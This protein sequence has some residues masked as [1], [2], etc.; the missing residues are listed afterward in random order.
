[1]ERRAEVAAYGTSGGWSVGEPQ[2]SRRIPA[3]PHGGSRMR[4]RRGPSTPFRSA[5]A[6]DGTPLR[7]TRCYLRIEN[8]GGAG[9]L[10]LDLLRG[11]R[12]PLLGDAG[13]FAGDGLQFA[14]QGHG[15]AAGFVG[16]GLF[17]FGGEVL[18]L[19]LE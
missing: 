12:L 14:V 10:L 16:V 15:A 1:M 9:W 18:L 5:F 6:R 13:E 19:R 4:G 3:V 2:R 11:E 7:M 17:E 8:G